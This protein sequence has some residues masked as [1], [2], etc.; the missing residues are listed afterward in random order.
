MKTLLLAVFGLVLQAKPAHAAAASNVV[1]SGAKNQIKLPAKNPWERNLAAH[2]HGQ[3]LE[4]QCAG[5]Q[6]Q[7]RPK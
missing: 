6:H 1:A 3:R 7:R 4:D 5:L 2:H